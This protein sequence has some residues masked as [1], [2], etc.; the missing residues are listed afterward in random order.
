[1][2]EF[3]PEMYGAKGDGESDDSA[4]FREL[5]SQTGDL[6]KLGGGEVT[7]APT[8]YLVDSVPADDPSGSNALVPLPV[9]GGSVRIRGVSGLTTIRTRAGSD[10]RSGELPAV[11][12]TSLFGQNY[13]RWEFEGF[14]IELPADPAL[15]GINLP[16]A[17]R[18]YMKD[19]QVVAANRGHA[20]PTHPQSFGVRLPGALNF[21]EVYCE[22]V[23]CLGPYCGIAF[24]ST[25]HVLLVNPVAQHCAVG[26]G[27]QDGGG[28]NGGHASSWLYCVSEHNKHHLAGWDPVAG[29]QSMPPEREPAHL[30]IHQF[31]IE[32]GSPPLDTVDHILDA[33]D[34]LFGSIAY[35]RWALTVTPSLSVVGGRNL[36]RRPVGLG[37]LATARTTPPDPDQL[38][39]GQAVLWL[40]AT[41]D[42]ARLMVT[43]KQADGTLRTGAIALD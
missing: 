24:A 30:T 35:N 18:V 13:G 20:V 27:I 38:A 9:L 33:N 19:I 43:A 23:Y 4:A 41:N 39:A 29:A 25:A 10:Y 32:D 31:D 8:T 7:L 22:A 17:G 15:G 1:M 2:H 40:D 16:L 6:A 42:A 37:H 21:G 28:M 3:T 5:F 14:T 36:D 34:K 12:G 11:F 26:Y